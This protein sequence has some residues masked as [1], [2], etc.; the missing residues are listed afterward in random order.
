MR[1]LPAVLENHAGIV[2]VAANSETIEYRL[3]PARHKLLLI[4]LAALLTIW[5]CSR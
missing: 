4:L 2:A 5:C 3:A 1:L